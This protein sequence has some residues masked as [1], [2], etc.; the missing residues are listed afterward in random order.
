MASHF[1]LDE[2]YKRLQKE[3]YDK[4]HR[5]RTL[6]SLPED[7]SVW[8]E[9]RGLQT[10]GRI[11]HAAD[12][13]RSYVVETASGDLRRNHAH[14]RTRSEAEETIVPTQ[15]FVGPNRPVA[16]S[17]TGTVVHPPDRLRY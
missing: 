4:H 10:P 9:T 5:V 1:K 15:S 16:R 13:P 14:L 6:P 17:Q 2:E 12:T 3:Y 7:Q 11:S 8:I